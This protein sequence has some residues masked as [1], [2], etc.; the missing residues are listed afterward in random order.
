MLSVKI[1]T[2]APNNQIIGCSGDFI[3]IKIKAPA[4]KEQANKELVK[5]LSASLKVPQSNI[6]IIKGKH[7]SIKKLFIKSNDSKVILRAIG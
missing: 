1:I 7:S 3:K 4:Q 2:N 6:N 5:F